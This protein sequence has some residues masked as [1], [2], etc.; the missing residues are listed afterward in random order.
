MARKRYKPEE[1]VT[2]LQQV[3]VLQSQGQS[4]GEAVRQIGV[5]ETTYFQW[6]RE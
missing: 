2:K 6:R 4:T 5:T 1:I 3:D